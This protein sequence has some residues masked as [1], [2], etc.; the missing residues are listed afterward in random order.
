MLIGM[1]EE[2]TAGS[3]PKVRFSSGD[4]LSLDEIEMK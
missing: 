1:G 2:R 4:P 3:D